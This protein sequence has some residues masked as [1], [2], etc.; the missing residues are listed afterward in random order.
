MAFGG[1]LAGGMLREGDP[2]YDEARQVHNGAIQR[3]P[4]LIARC[5]GVADVQD[6]IRFGREHGL[7]I[8][9]KGGGHNVAGRATCDGGL[10]I[11][12]SLMKGVHVD[13][14]ARTALAQ[15]GVT[16]GEFNRE[17]QVYGLATTGGIV[18]TTGIAG[19]TL[20]GGIGWLMGKHG[21][22]VDNLRAVELVT[23]EGEVVRASPEENQDLFWAVRGGGGNFAIVTSFEY[24]L[25]AVGPMV[26]G[27]LIA[28][29]FDNAKS[30]LRSYRDLAASLPDE[31]TIDCALLHAPDGS[32]AKIAGIVLCHCGSL[33]EGE[34]AV[35]PIKRF[36][37]PVMD[38]LGPIPYTQQNTLL[39]ENYPKGALNYWKSNFLRELSD[40][41]IDALVDQFS[42]CPS[43]MSELVLEHLHGATVRVDPAASAYGHRTEGFSFLVISQ[44][45][46]P[47]ETEINVA[48]ARK[49]YDAMKPFMAKDVYVNYLAE[50]ESAGRVEAAYGGNFARLRE[51]KRKYDPKN[52]FH[53]NQTIVPM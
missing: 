51:I 27:G 23:A 5:L 7:E 50:D 16:W 12:L 8:A 37:S 49:A 20:G 35:A 11:D 1:G 42:A 28:F 24:S 21:M 44:C 14:E 10:M 45:I 26:T 47:D 46:A 53:L 30:V 38:M 43:P 18:S 36:G 2:G 25:H 15:P 9:V 19:L 32:G 29:P 31:M 48:W 39:D 41:A 22:A 6:A 13:A 52:V 40:D 17:T 4:A 34:S 3:R 33:E